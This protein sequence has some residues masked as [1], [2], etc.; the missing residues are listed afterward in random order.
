M[1]TVPTV[2]AE[3]GQTLAF[4]E[5]TMTTVLR[6]HLAQRDVE[7]ETWYA[8]KLTAVGGPHI[9][10]TALVRDLEGSRGLDPDSVRALLARLAA[11]GLLA[12]DDVVDLTKTG[13]ILYENLRD[14]VLGATAGLLGGFDLRDIETTVRTL[15]AITKGAATADPAA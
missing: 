11:E 2:Y 10:R 15:K 7:P 5:R 1:S 9:A 14:H 4:T 13:T 6:Q 8:L 12:G 3:F